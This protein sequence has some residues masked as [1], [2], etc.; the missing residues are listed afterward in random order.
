MFESNES[1]STAAIATNDPLI[2]QL[3]A[4]PPLKTYQNRERAVRGVVARIQSASCSPVAREKVKTVRP[5]V[6]KPISAHDTR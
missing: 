4:P 2:A 3:A 5:L 1:T 6:T